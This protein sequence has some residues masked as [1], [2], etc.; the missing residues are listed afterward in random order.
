MKGTDHRR[1][2]T[3]AA[4]S[5]CVALLTGQFV[6]AKA[7][8]DALFLAHLSVTSLPAI[9]LAT[10]AISIAVAIG[11]AQLLRR[12]PPTRLV[13]FTLVAGTVLLLI[14]WVSFPHAP[15]LAAIV[16]YLQVSVFGPM[17][18]SGLWLIATERFDPR[19][20]KKAFGEMVAF[21][22]LGG[23]CG[24]VV[25]E[26]VAAT[27]G[28]LMVLP[29]L[30]VIG[31]LTVWQV[32]RLGQRAATE[33]V[34]DVPPELAPTPAESSVRALAG[35]PY[36]RNLAVLVLL[37]AVGSTLLDYLLKM[38]AVM[39]IGPGERLLQFFAL[40]YGATSVCVFVVQTTAHRPALAK[41]GLAGTVATPAVAVL[42]G[43]VWALIAPGLVSAGLVRG[44]ESVLRQSLFRSAYEVFYTPVSSTDKRAAKSIIDV[45]FDRLGDAIG[46]GLIV[47][48]LA[49][50]PFWDHAVI[51]SAAIGCSLCALAVT[52]R[53]TRGYV[54]ALERSLRERA[55][56]LPLNDILDSTTRT[57][58]WRTLTAAETAAHHDSKNPGSA[59]LV[60]AA[61]TSA[62]RK[63]DVP[64]DVDVLQ[65]LALRSCDRDRIARVLDSRNR[66]MPSVIPH[67]IP[68]LE[69]D[70][71]AG[72]AAQVLK[73]VAQEQVGALV[74]A[75]LD[76]G[77]P[78]TVR[79]R[80]ARVLA[81]NPCQRGVDGLFIGLTDPEFTL[82][83]QCGRSLAAICRVHT[84]LQVD[85]TRVFA[86][87]MSEVARG[88]S[89]W[90]SHRNLAQ[91]EDPD[92]PSFVDEY[93]KQRTDEGLAH[94][95]TLLSIV[96]PSE[97][98][99]IAYRGLHTNDQGLRGTALEYLES[100]L[101]LDVRQALWPFLDVSPSATGSSLSRQEIVARLMHAHPTILANL[102]QLAE[103]RQP[104]I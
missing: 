91:L 57:L 93:L 4:A 13:L 21:G 67:V 23:L 49:I 18:A 64:F 53:L 39:T 69:S 101:P 29:L 65:I 54:H 102:E 10:S 50:A 40:Y 37:G 38:H 84:E 41:L 28:S 89:V 2:G 1:D 6:A 51:V 27:W 19:S 33:R 7:A 86:A 16:F 52:L 97:P 85:I 61:P 71:F 58:V 36:L 88:R 81:A 75:V 9:I 34:T 62:P 80:L 77:Q 11:S 78:A 8:R 20:A 104:P 17:L 92:S 59:R 98:L 47:L 43:G 3:A 32:R 72:A 87:V 24:A 35:V 48:V 100:V 31:L 45:G 79:R 25:A 68:L 83:V 96:L 5:W 12:L 42:A 73:V 94:V 82:R 66:L 74:D 15:K 90:E 63:A 60:H 95:F 30:A 26:R 99:R 103:K 46:A 76:S 22:T 55:V 70:E 44:G 14:E 56:A